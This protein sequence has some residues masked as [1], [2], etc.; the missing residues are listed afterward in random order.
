MGGLSTKGLG[1]KS[2]NFFDQSGGDILDIS[3]R[4]DAKNQRAMQGF[5]EDDQ[6]AFNDMMNKMPTYD[7]GGLNKSFTK[8]DFLSWGKNIKA[9][10]SN[11]GQ[12]DKRM[13]Q[14]Q[15]LN[16]ADVK[17]GTNFNQAQQNIHALQDRAFGTETSPWAQ[18]LY[19]QQAVD[20]GRV[21]DQM[22]QNLANQTQGAMNQMAATTGIDAG[23]RERMMDKANVNNMN[24]MQ[25]LYSQGMSDRLGIGAQDE[26]Q[27]MALQQQMPGMNLQAD[28]YMTGVDF[29]NQAKDINQGQFNNNLSMQKANM[30]S[31]LADT[32]AQRKLGVDEFNKQGKIG[33]NQWNT[34]NLINDTNAAN[35]WAMQG[36]GQKMQ[37]TGSNSAANAMANS[38][39]KGGFFQKLFSI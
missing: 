2:S 14:A 20:Q 5:L 10:K 32:E 11:L 36:W 12:L 22:S 30:W 25:N 27:R 23:A 29:G 18:K 15:G 28:Q 34:G 26:A 37:G 4:K 38:G 8:D 1:T 7:N 6:A 16:I 31:G 21:Q 17:T 13:G 33:L 35:N 24:Q 39:Q 3:G 19:D 9:P